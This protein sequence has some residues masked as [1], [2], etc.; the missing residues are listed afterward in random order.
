MSRKRQ[1]Q[2]CS[3][4]SSPLLHLGY[5]EDAV[6]KVGT[7]VA[8]SLVV[9]AMVWAA[10]VKEGLAAAARRALAGGETVEG[11]AQGWVERGVLVKVA[12]AEECMA[13]TRVVAGVGE[14]TEVVVWE[15]AE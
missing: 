5:S 11:T 2:G 9:E 14:E 1:Q 7:R 12:E 6:A 15:E 10:E 13:A 4:P 8:I 3:Q